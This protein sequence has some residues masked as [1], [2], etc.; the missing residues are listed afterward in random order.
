MENCT[1]R[2]GSPGEPLHRSS[3]ADGQGSASV[4]V[5]FAPA[6]QAARMRHLR[7]EGA[8]D[9]RNGLVAGENDEKWPWSVECE[10][11]SQRMEGIR[12][13]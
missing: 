5:D 1:D 10:Q 13:S 9:R 12:R 2:P 3:L 6:G 4:E 11:C 7:P 8:T